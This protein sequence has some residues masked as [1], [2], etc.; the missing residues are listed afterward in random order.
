MGPFFIHLVG[1]S[2]GDGGRDFLLSRIQEARDPGIQGSKSSGIQKSRDPRI[3]VITSAVLEIVK[4][5]LMK[6]NNL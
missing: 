1:D 6:I 4:Q 3:Q 2:Q 5:I